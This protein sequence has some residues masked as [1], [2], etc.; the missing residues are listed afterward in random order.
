MKRLFIIMCMALFLLIS[1]PVYATEVEPLK[2]VATVEAENLN[3]R[4]GPSK[5]Y[6]KLGTLSQGMEIEV[7]GIVEPDWYVIDF[8]GEEGFISSDYVIFTPQDEIEGGF[9]LVA[10]KYVIMALLVAILL[11]S[12]ILIYTFI[13]IKKNPEDDEEDYIPVTDHD[14]T[15][16]HLGEVTYDTYRIDI[17]PKYFE[18]TTMIPQPESI[19]DEKK[20]SAWKKD[21]YGNKSAEKE[22]AEASVTSET[23]IQML[24]SK[25]E[26]ASAQIAALQKEVEQLRKQQTDSM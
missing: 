16:M 20:E 15:N 8:E 23:D 10:K 13:A 24:D 5:S 19:Y 18:Q 17:D 4:S 1:L 6:D 7:K 11:L 14:D 21:L 22:Q 9:T 3:V 12:G 26:Q 25:L 2:G